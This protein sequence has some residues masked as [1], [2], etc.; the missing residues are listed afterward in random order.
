MLVHFEAGNKACGREGGNDESCPLMHFQCSSRA[1]TIVARDKNPAITTVFSRL[2]HSLVI[3][4][5]KIHDQF[6]CFRH[7]LCLW[8][9]H[10]ILPSSDCHIP[11]VDWLYL[12][13]V[14]ILS[15]LSQHSCHCQ[16]QQNSF[17]PSSAVESITRSPPHPLLTIQVLI[18]IMRLQGLV[19]TVVFEHLVSF[20]WTD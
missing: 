5:K 9:T 1:W 8:A 12:E 20:G 17:L 15:T 16:S 10:L 4:F 2:T 14:L 11:S 18:W 13:Q 7:Q 19:S 3:L 6:D